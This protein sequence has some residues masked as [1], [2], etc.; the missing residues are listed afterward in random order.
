MVSN[1]NLHL[2]S[3]VTLATLLWASGAPLEGEPITDIPA[4]DLS[5]EE[6][7]EPMDELSRRWTEVLDITK[8]HKKEFE[9]EFHHNV[10]YD[11]LDNYKPP[12]LPERCPYS[13]FRKEACLQRLAEGLLKYSVLLKHVER[14]YPS[15]TILSGMKV[16]IEPMIK[17]IKERMK[18]SKR[19]TGLSSSQEEQLLKELSTPNTFHRKMTAHS[20][21]SNLINFLK[22]GK[23]A[24]INRER[25]RTNG[26]VTPINTFLPVS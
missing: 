5:G 25:M 24:I 7:E 22:D 11:H 16:N 19:V 15:S 12:S 9:D 14:E 23:R 1:L 6:W 20:I 18:H 3:A 17:L 8:G 4:G 26:N 13:N 21:L 10:K 2:L